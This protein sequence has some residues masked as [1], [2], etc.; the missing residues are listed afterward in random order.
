MRDIEYQRHS[1]GTIY[2]WLF[3]WMPY[4]VI[5]AGIAV[6][7]WTIAGGFPR[8]VSIAV[9]TWLVIVVLAFVAARSV[10]ESIPTKIEVGNEGVALSRHRRYRELSLDSIIA[11]D[12]DISSPYQ[13]LLS[14]WIRLRYERDG[15]IL[16]C[17]IGPYMNNYLDLIRFLN[18]HVSSCCRCNRDTFSWSVNMVVLLFAVATTAV[19]LSV[20]ALLTYSIAMGIAMFL[21]LIWLVW[22]AL[23]SPS[24]IRLTDHSI[25]LSRIW[26]RPFEVTWSDI[27][28]IEVGLGRYLSAGGLTIS[29]RKDG[30]VWVPP[31]FAHFLELMTCSVL[32]LEKQT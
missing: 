7:A 3:L 4:T 14:G 24:T 30:W 5:L 1:Y 32:Q 27:D 31:L 17:Y 13:W 20:I 16:Q 19:I 23:T 10:F 9:I 6:L 12:T 21:L 29:I 26:G 8:T 2:R 15:K 22:F 28:T 25:R 18:A 11:V